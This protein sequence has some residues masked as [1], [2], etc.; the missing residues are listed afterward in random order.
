MLTVTSIHKRL[1]GTQILGG[2]SLACAGGEIVVIAGDNG[3]GKS[4]LLRIMA[5]VLEPDRGAVDIDGESIIGRHVAARRK[6]GYVPES[7]DP[8]AHL[9]VAELL[10][11]VAALKRSPPL[12]REV[13]DALA[14]DRLRRRRIEQLSLGERRRV[15][16]GAALIG[17]P[18]VLILDEPSNGLDDDGAALLI[19]LLGDRR[20][21]DTA[22]VIATHDDD[23]G[24]AVATRWLRL[25]AGVLEEG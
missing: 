13:I 23:F 1:G 18:A 3:A 2:A 24:R 4:T 7:A 17:D 6:L 20:D 25:R 8:P 15:C 5:G 11:L 10:G 14:I 12:A 16:V 19:E 22:I 9:T 21:R